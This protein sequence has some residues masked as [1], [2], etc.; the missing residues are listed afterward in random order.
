MPRNA[1]ATGAVDYVLAPAQ[2]AAELARICQ[3]RYLAR[4]F[5][6]DD[7]EIF[8]DGEGELNQLLTLLLRAT[9]VDFRHYKQTTFRRRIGRRMLVHRSEDLKDYL[10]YVG[11]HPDE[12]EEL[13]RDLSDKRHVLLSRSGSI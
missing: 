13:Y 6:K 4:S 3:H 5:G 2:I 9:G 10:A 1:V 12:I 7:E 11:Q 8:P